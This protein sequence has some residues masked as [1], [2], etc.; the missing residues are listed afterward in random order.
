MRNTPPH[1]IYFLKKRLSVHW[2]LFG[3]NSLA[4]NVYFLEVIGNQSS[5]TRVLSKQ[6]AR[7][8]WKTLLVDGFERVN[9]RDAGAIPFHLDQRIREWY[10]FIRKGFYD[11]IYKD[12]PWG[13]GIV[14]GNDAKTLSRIADGITV[15]GVDDEEASRSMPF[16]DHTEQLDIS[17][18]DGDLDNYW[19]REGV[20]ESESDKGDEMARWMDAMLDMEGEDD[21]EIC[22][23][24]EESYQRFVMEQEK[25]YDEIANAIE[26]YYESEDGVGHH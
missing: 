14:Y 2:F 26:K 15:N 13:S 20:F 11:K 18:Q 24:Q 9:L 5:K 23:Q 1:P 17:D 25:R 10:Q 3:L 16:W 7:C 21:E 22:C 8:L 12:D 4:E 6:E 19:N